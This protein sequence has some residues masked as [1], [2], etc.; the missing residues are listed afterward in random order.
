MT[1]FMDQMILEVF[2]ILNDSM[3]L[4]QQNEGWKTLTVDL[5]SAK[6]HSP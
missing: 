5:I 1:Q 6:V 3:V 2:F 4:R